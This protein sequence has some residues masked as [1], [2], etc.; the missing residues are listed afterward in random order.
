MESNESRVV[1]LTLVRHGTTLWMEQGITHGRLD[2]PLSERGQQEVHLTAEALRGRSFD[3][4][5]ASPTGRA[6]QTA[7][8]IAEVIQ[9]DPTPDAGLMEYDFGE[10]EGTR[11]SG[12]FSRFAMIQKMAFGWWIS[13]WSGGE[14]FGAMHR[15]LKSALT[16]IVRRNPG[17]R[18]LVISHH[19][20]INMML[21]IISGQPFTFYKIAP[22]MVVEVEVDDHL[23]GKILTK[24]PK[25]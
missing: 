21:Q 22:A 10:K 6:M 9:K 16:E 1:K 15:R 5:Y 25:A 4:F 19:G 7:Q 8:A 23:R 14:S 12:K 18:V 11:F 24:L 3:A 20:A 13:P 2:A 17:Q